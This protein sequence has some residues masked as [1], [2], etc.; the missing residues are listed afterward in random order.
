MK[1]RSLLLIVAMLSICLLGIGTAYAITGVDDEVP[2]SN[3]VI[4]FVCQVGG[5][6]DT[7]WLFAD[8]F[9]SGGV[10]PLF[11]GY[12]DWA[13]FNASSIFVQDSFWT[14]TQC[15]TVTDSACDLISHDVADP[16]GMVQTI[17]G[18]DYYV[19]YLTVNYEDSSTISWPHTGLTYYAYLIDATKG[20]ASGFAPLIVENGQAGDW[21]EYNPITDHAQAMNAEMYFPRYLFVN[22]A[23]PETF[24]WWLFLYPYV[25]QSTTNNYAR[26]LDGIVCDENENCYSS[27]VKIPLELNIVDVSKVLPPALKPAGKNWSGFGAYEVC[28]PFYFNTGECD[29]FDWDASTEGW[30]YE[31]AQG[32]SLAATW[33]VMHK[34]PR[35]S[36]RLATLPGPPL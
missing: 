2:A 12:V 22:S 9:C 17:G 34:I 6:L 10:P 4:P 32:S 19:G 30:S 33:D 25:D 28:E 11:N 21:E 1:K 36:G 3:A 16:S 7:S 14:I 8:V 23:L 26:A 13:M 29:T 18:R 15:G 31:R 5:G 35:V 27:V 20:F 24:N